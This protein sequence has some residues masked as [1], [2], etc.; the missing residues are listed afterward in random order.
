MK[1]KYFLGI[2]FAFVII[3]FCGCTT[4]EDSAKQA[5]KEKDYQKV[6]SL[7]KDKKDK[8]KESNEIFLLSTAH[9][10]LKEKRYDYALKIA[11][12][13]EGDE[14]EKIAQQCNYNLI[15]SEL[16]AAIKNND[17]ESTFITYAKSQETLDDENRKIITA[18]LVD[19]FDD[20]ASENNLDSI[21]YL[22]DVASQLRS[23]EDFKESE[24]AAALDKTI[25]NSAESKQKIFLISN[26]WLRQDD[27]NMSGTKIK[28]QFNNNDGFATIEET[29]AVGQEAGFGQGDIKWK[30]IQFVDSNTFRYEEL[31]KGEAQTYYFEGIAKVDYFEKRINN[32]ISSSQNTNGINQIYVAVSSE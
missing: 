32:H 26:I 30:N 20:K 16:D 25:A 8:T 17:H 21:F 2:V 9:V 27:T 23:S 19:S 5:Y 7:L 22:E 6:V 29:T 15:K 1:R 24:L 3:F 28:I 12:S 18:G 13:V 31:A 10:A 4:D 11:G 14:S